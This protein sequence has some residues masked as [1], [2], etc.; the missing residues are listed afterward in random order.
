MAILISPSKTAGKVRKSEIFTGQFQKAEIFTIMNINIVLES[1]F[2]ILFRSS[3]VVDQHD[4]KY[5]LTQEYSSKW[6]F[7]LCFAYAGIYN[8]YCLFLVFAT[9]FPD[10]RLGY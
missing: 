3:I 9:D 10:S 7:Y 5:I 4:L 1:I 6:C 2:L 8:L